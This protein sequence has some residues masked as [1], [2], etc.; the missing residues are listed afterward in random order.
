MKK[1][2]LLLT[3]LA[4]ILI[5]AGCCTPKTDTVTQVSAIDALLE[6]AYDGNM[7]C[8]DLLRHGD[9]GIGTFHSLDGEMILLDGQLHQVCADGR[10]LSPPRQ[11]TTPFASV[12]YF[13]ADN[14]AR[15]ENGT[16]FKDFQQFC[17]RLASGPTAICAIKVTGDFSFV[18]TRS[19]PAQKKPYPPLTEVT[20]T[21]PEFS[22]T[23]TAGTLIGFR[24]PPLM[25]GVN[26]PGYHLHF[27]SADKSF[28]GHVL[29]FT[30]AGGTLEIDECHRFFMVLPEGD[31]DFGRVDF[32]RDRTKDLEK[33]EQ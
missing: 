21:Q 9:F 12:L 13:K 18:K 32:T 31:S 2:T 25:K 28:G 11:T 29:D 6:G 17:D 22:A 14:V 27:L 20:K 3:A 24:L 30:L 15:V 7:A 23:N 8:A 19:V 5:L 33:A 4:A 1:I 26:V 10:V 16:T